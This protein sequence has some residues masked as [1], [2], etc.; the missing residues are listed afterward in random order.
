MY[1]NSMHSKKRNRH[2]K[3][4]HHTPSPVL[5]LLNGNIHHQVAYIASIWACISLFTLSVSLFVCLSLFPLFS[6]HPSFPLTFSP[7][8]LGSPSPPLSSPPLPLSACPRPSSNSV[9]IN[10]LLWPLASSF[11]MVASAHCLARAWGKLLL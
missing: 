10:S 5:Q 7:S 4:A 2:F 8:L 11:T 6:P 3:W 9:F 1:E